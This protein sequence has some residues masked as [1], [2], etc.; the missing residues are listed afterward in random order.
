[1]R[2]EAMRRWVAVGI[3]AAGGFFSLAQSPVQS[4][5]SPSVEPAAPAPQAAGAPPQA[6]AVPAVTGGKLHGTVKSG[7]IPLPGVTVTAQRCV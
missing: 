1:M 6:P 2:Q 7:N 4:P 5:T 3:F